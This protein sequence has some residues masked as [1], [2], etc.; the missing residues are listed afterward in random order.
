MGEKKDVK[1]KVACSGL[2]GSVAKQTAGEGERKT[3]CQ[4]GDG[5]KNFFVC[6]GQGGGG[7]KKKGKIARITVVS[8]GHGFAFPQILSSFLFWGRKKNGT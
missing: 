4:K 2:G 5:K 8:P 6:C 7:E 1:A 3:S